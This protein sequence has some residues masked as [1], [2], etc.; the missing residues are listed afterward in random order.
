MITCEVLKSLS[1]YPR[2]LH[3]SDNKLVLWF[4]S[5]IHIFLYNNTILLAFSITASAIAD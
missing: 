2:R 3:T 4:E 5:L 1:I